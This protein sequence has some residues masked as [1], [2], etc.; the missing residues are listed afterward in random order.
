[1]ANIAREWALIGVGAFMNQEVIGLRKPS[2]TVLADE[3]LLWA[4]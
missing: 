4:M 2:L 1:M 3:L